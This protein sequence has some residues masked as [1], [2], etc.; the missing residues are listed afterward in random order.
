[1]AIQRPASD[2]S[3]GGWTSTAATAAE[4]LDEVSAS[5]ADY[6]ETA[7]TGDKCRVSLGTYTDPGNDNDHEVHYRASSA[8]ANHGLLVRLLELGQPPAIITSKQPWRQQPLKPVAIDRNNPFGSRL[9]NGLNGGSFSDIT[10]TPFTSVTSGVSVGAG[11]LQFAGTV[12]NR[13][14]YRAPINLGQSFTIV[15]RVKHEAGIYN[16]SFFDTKRFSNWGTA[17]GFELNGRPDGGLM[18]RVGIEYAQ[19]VTNYLNNGLEHDIAA[20]FEAGA[21]QKIFVDGVE[22]SY[23]SSDIA[24]AYIASADPLV[25][26]AYYSFDN[27]A[28]LSGYIR[29]LYLFHSAFSI[30]QV[31]EVSKNPWQ[32]LKPKNRPIFFD[33]PKLIASHTKTAAQLGTSPAD[34]TLALSTGEAATITNG[35]EL[36]LEFEATTP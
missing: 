27:W 26:G 4:V 32:V 21:Q 14:Q 17:V 13:V 28:T 2:V 22:V 36:A 8:D 23:S 12:G 1:M 9:V 30:E 33:A 34:Q 16:G 18:F 35:A 3:T 25:S 7:T 20:V 29:Y 31:K 19:T 10:N 6:V 11:Q 5:D 15:G 24:G